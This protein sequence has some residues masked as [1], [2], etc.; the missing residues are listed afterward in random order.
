MRTNRGPMT[1]ND[2][3][4]IG[5]G[6]KGIGMFRKDSKKREKYHRKKLYCPW[7]KTTLNFIEIRNREEAKEFKEQFAAG[8]FEQEAIESREKMAEDETYRKFME[9]GI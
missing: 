1:F 8:E 4:C 6:E 3:Y 5:C 2:F 7:C 9:V